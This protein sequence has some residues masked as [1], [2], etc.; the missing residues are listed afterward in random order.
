MSQKRGNK[1]AKQLVEPVGFKNAV[2]SEVVASIMPLDSV[3]AWV[4]VDNFSTGTPIVDVIVPK[5]TRFVTFEEMK[6]AVREHYLIFN[7]TSPDL[8]ESLQ[9]LLNEK[10]VDVF[11]RGPH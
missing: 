1:T 9:F 10:E 3:P 11:H 2:L 8:R 6:R 5:W 4:G 7:V